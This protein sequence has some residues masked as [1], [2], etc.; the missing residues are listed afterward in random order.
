[1]QLLLNDKRIKSGQNFSE[2]KSLLKEY[3]MDATIPE[4]Y[5][6]IIFHGKLLLEEIDHEVVIHIYF[7]KEKEELQ[8]M[9]LHPSPMNFEKMQL[10]LENQFQKPH[11]VSGEKEVSWKFEDGEIM[12]K[13]TKRFGE[14]EMVYLKFDNI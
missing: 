13:I 10:F 12:H 5:P 6:E 14:E 1:M 7:D 4:D 8:S 11:I 2:I 9:V 3:R